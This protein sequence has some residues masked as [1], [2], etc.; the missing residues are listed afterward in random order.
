VLNIDKKI[1]F[2]D[3]SF[4]IIFAFLILEYLQNDEIII[5]ELNKKLK[6]HGYLILQVPNKDNLRH[7]LTRRK[8]AQFHLREYSIKEISNL[9]K[10]NNFIIEKIW[11][12][13]FYS[14]IF[15]NTLNYVFEILLPHKI[16]DFVSS[17][18]P[19]KYR[20]IINVIA[21]KK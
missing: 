21:R 1:P 15:T 4:N 11:T 3:R 9:L 6:E 5:Q 13:R 12:E 18:T 20:G 19:Q 8:L 10:N 2:Q 7:L 17:I 16:L 14:P